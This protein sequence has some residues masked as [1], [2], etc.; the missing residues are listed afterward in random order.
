MTFKNIKNIIIQNLKN[1]LPKLVINGDR[2]RKSHNVI[3][4]VVATCWIVHRDLGARDYIFAFA[5]LVNTSIIN[6][7]LFYYNY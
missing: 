7:L 6:L 5:I 1:I 4:V 2:K 3:A